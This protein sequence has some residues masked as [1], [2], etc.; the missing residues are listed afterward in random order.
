MKVVRSFITVFAL[1]SPLTS[2]DAKATVVPIDAQLKAVLKGTQPCRV[3]GVTKKIDLPLSDIIFVLAQLHAK[4]IGPISAGQVNTLLKEC[5]D[6]YVAKIEELY[7][8]ISQQMQHTDPQDRQK[9]FETLAK[10][11]DK[12]FVILKNIIPAATDCNFFNG[13]QENVTTIKTGI[14]LHFEDKSD[15]FRQKLGE[16]EFYRSSMLQLII[17]NEY[18]FSKYPLEQDE[19]DFV[20]S[21]IVRLLKSS[22]IFVIYNILSVDSTSIPFDGNE[23]FFSNLLARYSTYS[24]PTVEKLVVQC[25]IDRGKKSIPTTDL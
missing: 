5:Q 11:D 24:S 6:L 20:K 9:F 16:V 3:I 4:Y 15:K 18:F 23:S 7:L 19:V 1:L 14:S 10:S 8:G 25:I 2:F 22:N 21:L 17:F 12:F 13:S